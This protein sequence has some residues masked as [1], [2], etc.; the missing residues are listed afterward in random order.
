MKPIEVNK[1]NKRYIKQIAYT[2][3]KTNKNSKYKIN[4]LARIS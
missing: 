1:S 3:N 4:D 2:Y